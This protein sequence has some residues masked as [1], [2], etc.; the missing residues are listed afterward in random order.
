MGSQQDVQ[1]RPA[2]QGVIGGRR[3]DIVDVRPVAEQVPRSERLGHGGLVADRP[4]A[5]VEQ[6]RPRLHPRKRLAVD[7]PPGRGVERDVQGHV[8]GLG[9]QLIERDPGRPPGRASASGGIAI[10]SV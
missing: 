7:H 9:E 10:T 2:D 5:G 1:V 4:P 8:I 3:L 6:D